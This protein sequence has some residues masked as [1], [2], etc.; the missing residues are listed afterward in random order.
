MHAILQKSP[1]LHDFTTIFGFL[2]TGD[3]NIIKNEWEKLEVFEKAFC[4]CTSLF[5][6]FFARIGASW[7]GYDSCSPGETLL[8]EGMQIQC[9]KPW[10]LRW[11]AFKSWQR[12][13]LVSFEY[14]NYMSLSVSQ[15]NFIYF[16]YNQSAR[17]LPNNAPKRSTALAAP[18]IRLQLKNDTKRT[19]RCTWLKVHVPEAAAGSSDQTPAGRRGIP[20]SRSTSRIITDHSL[21]LKSLLSSF[22]LF[23]GR[24]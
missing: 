6:R 1:I 8:N 11:K 22:P 19:A 17:A 7:Q 2:W 5:G 4:R 23:Q 15:I 14:K 24:R 16:S 9:S 13:V 18:I 20:T 3:K 12:L 21:C 10:A